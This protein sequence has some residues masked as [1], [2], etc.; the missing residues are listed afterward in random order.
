MKRIVVGVDGSPGSARAL[1]WAIG[2]AQHEEAEIVAVYALGPV[3]D[4]ARGASN[5]VAAGLGL[6]SSEAGSWLGSRWTFAGCRPFCSSKSAS[7]VRLTHS[8]MPLT[9]RK[10]WE[11]IRSPSASGP[12]LTSS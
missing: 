9:E 8:R 7:K 6:P 2:L 3:E 12:P 1:R 5:A 11:I 4:L 10:F